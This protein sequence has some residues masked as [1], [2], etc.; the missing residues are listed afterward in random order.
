ML[1]TWRLFV[2]WCLG[3]GIYY[4]MRFGFHISIAGGFSKVVERALKKKC[5]TIQL[6]SRNPRGWRYGPLDSKEIET[7]KRDIA[8]SGLYPIFIHLPYLPNLA[9]RKEEFYQSSI[10]SLVEELKRSEVLGAEFVITHIGKR[11]DT[12][13][14]E[15]IKR[16]AHAINSAFD[17]VKN[18]I[19]LLLE[20]TA[21]Q[22]TEIG[23]LFPQI[24]EILDRIVKND[25]LGVC[26]DTAHAFGSGYDL[27]TEK[28]VE[29][30]FQEFDE[31]I[32]L[33]RLKGLHLNDSLAPR[34]S[35]KDRHWHIGKGE[36]GLEGFRSIVNHPALTHI[37]GI[38][39]TPRDPETHS[40][41]ADDLRNM[42][43]LRK[44][45]ESQVSKRK[46]PRS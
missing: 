42:R 4:D 15:G 10:S 44:L 17:S 43:V 8:S 37:P 7:F 34:G 6:F 32:G 12:S 20:N 39:E 11:L 38:M 45:R 14:E 30:T 41:D 19:T 5:E 3:V 9:S 23:Y 16:V 13:E 33:D 27:S 26:L 28:G 25:R 22:G 1:D 40:G 2:I 36:I 24:R 35:R 46:S 31:I 29:K 18:G 21:G